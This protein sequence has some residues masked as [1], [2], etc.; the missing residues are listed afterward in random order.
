MNNPSYVVITPVR[1]EEKYVGKT[2]ESMVN[3]TILPKEWIIV[4]DGSTDQTPLIIDEAARK[5]PWIRTV[6]RPNR[7]FRK[8]GGGVIEAFYDGY[9]ALSFHDWEF[10]VKLDADISFASHYFESLLKRFVDD[11]RLG[12]ASGIYLEMENDGVSRPVQMPPYHAAGACKVIRRKCFEDINGFVVASGWDT[13]DEIRAMARGWITRHFLDL[14]IMHHKPEGS[15]IGMIR[16]SV[17]HGR[18]YY[19][20]GGGVLFFALKV[21]RRIGTKPYMLNAIALLLGHMMALIRRETLLVTEFESRYYR[22]LLRNRLKRQLRK[23]LA[24]I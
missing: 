19:R 24:G 22:N 15:G 3:Q 7:G 13:V 1:N 12:I 21:L 16:T 11:K 17:M 20:T 23:L 4:D 8:S 18:I 6:H 2:I 9:N 10:I 5:H 14:P